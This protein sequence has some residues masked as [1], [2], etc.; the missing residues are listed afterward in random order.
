[1]FT[2]ASFAG[3]L[4]MLNSGSL[5]F[6]YYDDYAFESYFPWRVPSMILDNYLST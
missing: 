5:G 6:S 2:A 1:M 3:K 4:Q